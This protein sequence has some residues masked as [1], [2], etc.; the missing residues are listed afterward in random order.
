[1]EGVIVTNGLYSNEKLVVQTVP[2]VVARAIGV[3]LVVLH[4]DDLGYL[5]ATLPAN[6]DRHVPTIGFIAHMDTSFRALPAS[7]NARKK[8]KEKKRNREM[9][10][11]HSSISFY[12]NKF[13]RN[14]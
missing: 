4:L 12:K 10:I 14:D 8:R 7:A 5:Y 9:A 3:E 1:V 2:L 6:T 11:G 13:L